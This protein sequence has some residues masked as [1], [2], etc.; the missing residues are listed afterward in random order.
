MVPAWSRGRQ[1]QFE[2]H[3]MRPVWP[4]APNSQGMQ[5]H[6]DIWVEDL[7]GG[8]EWATEC[9]ATEATPQSEGRDLDRIR[10]MLD[11]AGIRSASGPD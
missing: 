8:V 9:G 3:Y 1:H 6:L 2:E 11:P 10:V 7:R 5:I 4:G